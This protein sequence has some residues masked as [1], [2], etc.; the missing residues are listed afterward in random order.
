MLNNEYNVF[1]DYPE[2][3]E[4]RKKDS[5]WST[6][7]KEENIIVCQ[8]GKLAICKDWRYDSKPSFVDYARKLGFE[9]EIFGN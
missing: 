8:D 6:S 9:I 7:A 3:T 5:S 4:F 1:I 2:L